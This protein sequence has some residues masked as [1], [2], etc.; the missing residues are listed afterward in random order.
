MKSPSGAYHVT[1]QT[2]GDFLY[3][4]S[5]VGSFGYTKSIPRYAK[6]D[7]RGDLHRS[8]RAGAYREIDFY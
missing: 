6:A 8:G 3:G 4:K 5:A 1:A 2:E 7:R